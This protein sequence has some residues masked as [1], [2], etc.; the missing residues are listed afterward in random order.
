MVVV[1]PLKERVRFD[2]LHA[3]STYPVLLLAAKPV[4]DMSSVNTVHSS[5]VQSSA[6]VRRLRT[7]LVI[8]GLF[9]LAVTLVAGTTL[10]IK[11]KLRFPVCPFVIERTLQVQGCK[12]QHT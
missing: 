4:H 9:T 2:L 8:P 11:A 12:H 3:H 1:H 7:S 6:N 5:R 10:I